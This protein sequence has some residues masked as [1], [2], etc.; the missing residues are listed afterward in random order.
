MTIDRNKVRSALKRVRIRGNALLD[1]LRPEEAIDPLTGEKEVQFL[2]GF[3]ELTAA[4]LELAAVFEQEGQVSE[5][6]EFFA[7]VGDSVVRAQKKLD[8][9]SELYLEEIRHKDHILP[10]V[11]RIPKVSAEIKFA[12]QS[13]EARKI[14][15]LF[16]S[17]KEQSQE[18]HEQSVRFD[19]VAAPPPQEA[20]QRIA[21]RAKDGGKPPKIEFILA[22]AER[23]QIFRKLE[24]LVPG[25]NID[26]LQAKPDRV[27]IIPEGPEGQYYLLLADPDTEKN[28]GVWRLDLLPEPPVLDVVYSFA[29]SPAPSEKI[30][31]IKLHKELIKICNEQELFL[32][33]LR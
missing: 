24:I 27:L 25:K 16:Y 19:I 9:E 20:V 1:L 32:A 12:L 33:K 28:I 23:H 3:Q 29:R 4:Y 11:F 8:S 5:F 6:G 18:K 10:S 7:A 30:G 2:T 15:L 22:L 31:T 14:N 13:V 21:A 17:I 26:R